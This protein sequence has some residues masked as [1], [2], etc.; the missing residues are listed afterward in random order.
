[1]GILFFCLC[2]FH[3]STFT[4]TLSVIRAGNVRI[5]AQGNPKLIHVDN[6]DEV[7]LFYELAKVCE[8]HFGRKMI[9]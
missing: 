2:L 9:F 1:M 6:Y 3:S 7:F 4:E 5:T 8:K